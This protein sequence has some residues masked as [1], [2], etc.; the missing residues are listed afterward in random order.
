MT[1]SARLSASIDLLAAM[2]A[3]P[4]KPADAIAN[5]F[6]RERRYIGGGDRRAIS[7][8]VWD[9]MRGWRRLGWWLEQQGQ[10]PTPRLLAG[11]QLLFDGMSVQDVAFL[12]VGGRFAAGKLSPAEQ[13]ALAALDGQELVSPAMPRA[14]V[15]EVPEWLLVR[16]EDTFGKDVERELAA[17]STPA[18]LDLRVNILRSTRTEASRSLAR[19]GLHAE[20]TTLS[21]WGLRLE[22]RQPVTASVAFREGLVEIQDEG[23]QLVAAITGV[24]PGMRVLDYC[25]GAGGKTLAMAMM[26]ENKGHVVACDVSEPR[27]EGAVKRLRRAGVHNVERHLLVEGDRWAKRRSGSFDRVLVDAPCS[28]TGTWRRNPDARVRTT[29][30]DLEELL[31]KQAAIL[32]RAATLVRPGGRLIYATCSL[33]RAENADQV[34]AFLGRNPQFSLV[35]SLSPFMPEALRERDMVALTPAR[36][37]TDGF[38]AAVME[39]AES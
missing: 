13:A 35:P 15:L 9:V 14:V 16:L 21:P 29:Q 38:F 6:F 27:L 23:S 32:D 20:D 30:T 26:M 8:L 39:R 5:S 31:V 7:A 2:E 25:A 37:G 17:L 28:G 22:G 4:R 34:Q 36:D 3:A 12:Y 1:P 18:P 24:E 10:K 19:E 33:L 11:A